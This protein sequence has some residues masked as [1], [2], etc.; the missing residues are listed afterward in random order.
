MSTPPSEYLEFKLVVIPYEEGDPAHR[1]T[2]QGPTFTA[3]TG[4]T[5]RVV[6]NPGYSIRQLQDHFGGNS[7]YLT[8]PHGGK[9]F[10]DLSPWIDKDLDKTRLRIKYISPRFKDPRGTLR[11]KE[12]QT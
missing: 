7:G 8:D 6:S 10:L 2:L 11:A 4:E 1:I 5:S 12:S 3:K 9:H